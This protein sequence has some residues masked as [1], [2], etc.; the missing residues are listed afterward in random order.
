MSIGGSILV[1]VTAEIG[2]RV[3]SRNPEWAG[4]AGERSDSH[5]ESFGRNGIDLWVRIVTSVAYVR[6]S[7]GMGKAPPR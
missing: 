6:V 3:H 7:E 4:K 2:L 5:A 1:V